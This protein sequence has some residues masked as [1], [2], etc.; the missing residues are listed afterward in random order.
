[1]LETGLLPDISDN[2]YDD[3]FLA[4]LQMIEQVLQ[5]R[6]FGPY[7]Q[8]FLENIVS[9]GKSVFVFNL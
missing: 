5:D 3:C 8:A 4:Y 6:T 2:A 7:V 1:M 9:W